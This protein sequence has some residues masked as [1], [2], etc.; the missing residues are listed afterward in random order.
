[1]SI[2]RK[3]WGKQHRGLW[4]PLSW[5]SKQEF[6]CLLAYFCIQRTVMDFTWISKQKKLVSASKSR[7]ECGASLCLR[8]R[9]RLCRY[10]QPGSRIPTF[11][12]PYNLQKSLSFPVW[13]IFFNLALFFLTSQVLPQ[14]LAWEAAV[15]RCKRMDWSI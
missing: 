13:L 5:V 10:Q 6:V 9:Q 7:A 2:P 11:H 1:M 12:H 3:V 15:R 4:K 8:T 14:S